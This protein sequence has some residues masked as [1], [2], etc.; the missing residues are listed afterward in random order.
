MSKLCQARSDLNRPGGATRTVKASRSGVYGKGRER[1]QRILAEGFPDGAQAQP[2]R[3]GASGGDALFRQPLTPDRTGGV[4]RPYRVDDTDRE[5]LVTPQAKGAEP[6]SQAQTPVEAEEE[7]PVQRKAGSSSQ[8]GG[9]LSGAQESNVRSLAAGGE[10]LNQTTRSFFEPRMGTDLGDVRVHAD[11]RSGQLA[12]QLNARAFAYGQHVVFAPGEY[13]PESTAGRRLLAHE[14]THVLQ[15]RDAEP[16]AQPIR[17]EVAHWYSPWLQDFEYG[18]GSSFVPINVEL[19]SA[20]DV[21]SGW[22]RDATSSALLAGV[23]ALSGA[24]ISKRLGAWF[25]GAGL[26]AYSAY[27]GVHVEERVWGKLIDFHEWYGRYR[28]NVVTGNTVA[29]DFH[30]VGPTQT[31]LMI[32]YY[33]QERVAD[34]DGNS[35]YEHTRFEMNIPGVPALPPAFPEHSYGDFD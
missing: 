34:A 24:I 32:P 25:L 22:T 33:F 10:P 8:Q 1:V 16:A 11:A 17:R 15:Q 3:R 18:S 20:R 35:L 19:G 2:I 27:E 30:G 12:Q 29:V 4:I 26:A 7:I 31:T 23:T 21:D 13:Q 28:V 9:T 5:F 6:S 14:L